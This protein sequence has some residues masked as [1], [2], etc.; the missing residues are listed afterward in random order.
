MKVRFLM[1]AARRTFS[2]TVEH[3]IGK[4]AAAL[5]YY[6]LFAMFPILIFIN[7]LL[8]MLNWNVTAISNVLLPVLPREVVSMLEAYLTY[9]RGES[10]Y[11][12]IWFSLAFSVWFPLRAVRSLTND[13]RLAYQL[14]KP[15]DPVGYALRQMVFTLVFLV[16]V[17]LTLL[18]CVLGRRFLSA[19]AGWLKLGRRLRIPASGLDLW[20][21][22]RFLLLGALMFLILV[23]L[24]TVAQDRRPPV[25]TLLP[26][27]TLSL[28]SW[29]VISIGFSVYVENFGKYSIVY[30]AL[31]TVIVLLIWLYMTSFILILGAEFNAALAQAGGSRRASCNEI[32]PSVDR[33][34]S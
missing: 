15:A 10:S 29:L 17:T 23:L 31:G 28:V 20:Q 6:L 5:T 32:Q 19:A 7:S 14:G 22:F 8:G 27:I 21:Y 13:V 9:I 34:I 12:L 24:Y 1:R 11:V 4:S 18:L 16:I 3:E 25:R 33:M 2:N 30:G 26:G